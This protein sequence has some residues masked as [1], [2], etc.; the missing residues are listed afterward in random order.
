MNIND[1]YHLRNDMRRIMDNVLY[2]THKKFYI[3]LSDDIAYNIIIH[4]WN[5]IYDDNSFE[6]KKFL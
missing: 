1:L 5:K 6:M 4:V 2:K 3:F